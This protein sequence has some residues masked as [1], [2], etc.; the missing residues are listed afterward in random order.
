MTDKTLEILKLIREKCDLDKIRQDII[1]DFDGML[2]DL[3]KQSLSKKALL[4]YM[5][6]DMT[7]LL[8]KP[9]WSETDKN[10]IFFY[11]GNL[12]ARVNKELDND[13]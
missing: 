2:A 1:K 4:H 9:Q 3:E 7:L 13:L 12:M 11:L 10:S 5:L 6:E 8:N